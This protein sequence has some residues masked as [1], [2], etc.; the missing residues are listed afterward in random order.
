MRRFQNYRALGMDHLHLSTHGIGETLD[1]IVG[2]PGAYAKQEELKAW[3]RAD[4]WPY[5]V[6]VA[7]QQLNYKQLPALAAHEVE[8]GAYHFV[9]LGF[10]PHYEWKGHVA[11]VAVHPA[12]LRPAIEDAADVLLKAGTLLTI[13]YHPLCHLRSDLWKYVVNARYVFFD[14][15]E[16]NYP[17]ETRDAARLWQEAVACG[18]TVACHEPCSGCLAY[19]HCGGW[20][21]VYA[22]A[23]DGAGLTPVREVPHEYA[24]VWERDG[25]LHDLNPA[26]AETGTI[27]ATVT[28]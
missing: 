26:N 8:S 25:G 20:N 6:N 7:V 9:S 11:S 13:R 18:E 24:G 21:R 28:A 12:E 15:W 27:G 2:A 16:W 19:R 10:L 1:T 3:L 4:G 23:F 17:L 22:A 5:R 14:P